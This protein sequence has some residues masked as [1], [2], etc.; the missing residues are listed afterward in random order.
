MES[1]MAA[2]QIRYNE[3]RKRVEDAPDHEWPMILHDH[4]GATCHDCLT[5]VR[6]ELN[7]LAARAERAE[8]ERDELRS[9]VAKLE[10][11]AT[12]AKKYVYEDD[13]H[14]NYLRLDKALEKLEAK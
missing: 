11:V 7:A 2:Y 5:K 10:A 14:S 13:T 6:D 3:V 9:R 1:L 4:G 12:A 8:R